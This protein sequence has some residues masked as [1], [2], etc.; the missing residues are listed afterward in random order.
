M[1]KIKEKIQQVRDKIADACQ[2]RGR[3]SSEVKLVIVTKMAH[4]E[5]VKNVIKAGYTD[6]GE[7]RVQHL[8]K[9]SEEI[10]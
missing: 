7:N 4:L 2:R 1:L 8:K 3:E 6:F 5:N 9:V 10:R